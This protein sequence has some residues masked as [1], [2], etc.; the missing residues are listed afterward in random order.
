LVSEY[1]EGKESKSAVK[2]AENH[3][4]ME[5]IEVEIFVTKFF[6]SEL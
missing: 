6:S 1:F 5:K 4:L 3:I 2:I